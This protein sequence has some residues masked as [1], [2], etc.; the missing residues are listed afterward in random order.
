LLIKCI[1]ISIDEVLNR[2][3]RR[4]AVPTTMAKVNVKIEITAFR[5]KKLQHSEII[6]TKSQRD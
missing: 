6:P 5:D 2:K 3:R 1:G 4:F